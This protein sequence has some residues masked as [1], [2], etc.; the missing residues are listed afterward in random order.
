MQFKHMVFL[1]H[2]KKRGTPNL[3][4][5]TPV[6]MRYRILKSSGNSELSRAPRIGRW[7]PPCRSL[8]SQTIFHWKRLRRRS[9]GG[10]VSV[11]SQKKPSHVRDG[12]KATAAHLRSL[13]SL[14]PSSSGNQRFDAAPA[15]TWPPRFDCLQI[16]SR[17]THHRVTDTLHYSCELLSRSNQAQK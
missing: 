3:P 6:P 15:L 17:V 2:C 14:L 10:S 4:F 5:G 16:R 1:G 7:G 8:S 11:L 12:D 9:W 13:P